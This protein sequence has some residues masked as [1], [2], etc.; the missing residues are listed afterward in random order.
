MTTNPIEDVKTLRRL[1]MTLDK[2]VT[3]Y[4]EGDPDPAEAAGL[5]LEMNLA[6]LDVS[7]LY[8]SVEGRLISL[9]K[10]DIMTLR[11]GAIIERRTASSRTKWQHKEIASAVVDR[12]IRSSVDVDTGEVMLA[13]T[14]IAMKILDYVQPSY[15]RAKKLGE[16][17]INPDMYCESEHKTNIVVRK[18]NAE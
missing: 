18:G 10:D 11:D 14:D 17:G 12:I 13:P 1:I 2:I 9:L 8:S 5:F 7:Y 15:W 3:D 6:K 16:I 4:I